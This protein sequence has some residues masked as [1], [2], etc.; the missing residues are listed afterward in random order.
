MSIYEEH[1]YKNRR[2]YLESLADDYGLP[3]ETVF[4]LAYVLGRSE[5]FDALVTE[6]EDIAY[7]MEVESDEEE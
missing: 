2:E 5:D 4:N 7:R 1:G 3:Y 6:C